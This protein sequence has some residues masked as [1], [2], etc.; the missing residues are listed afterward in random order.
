MKKS[1]AG[2]WIARF[3]FTWVLLFVVWL[4]FTS[5][6]ALQEVL[7]GAVVS[8][9]I[10][11]PTSRFFTDVH[12]RLFN[13]VNLIYII[14]YLFIF[15]WALIVANLDVARRVISPKSKLPINPGIVSFKTDLKS[16]FAK[17]VL[18]NS[19]TLTPG[20]LS[21]DIIDDTF[22]IHWIDVKSLDAEKNKEEIAGKFEKVL[23]KIF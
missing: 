11:I 17:M 12:P 3:L 14:E 20:T 13:P 10:A 21:V 16:E 5:T 19:I 4:M 2:G 15:L 6:L 9:L 23:L 18:A 22:Y 7:T 1:S 8:L